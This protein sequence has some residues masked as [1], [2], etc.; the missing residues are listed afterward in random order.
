[1]RFIKEVSFY[2]DQNSHWVAEINGRHEWDAV[3][4][5]WQVNRQKGWRTV[6]L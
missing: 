2:D 3:N 6:E 4:T 1:M 5:G